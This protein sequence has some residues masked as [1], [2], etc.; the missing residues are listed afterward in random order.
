MKAIFHHTYDVEAANG[1]YHPL[2]FTQKQLEGYA[3]LRSFWATYARC[4]TAV[5]LK[6]YTD[7]PELS[8]TYH[9]ELWGPKEGGFDVYENDVM[10][11]NILLPEENGGQVRAFLARH[12]EF[13][14]LRE[15]TLTPDEDGTDGFYFAV[16]EKKETSADA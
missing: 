11:A 14:L 3:S 2:R 5:S 15:R 10:H 16:L 13:S 6:F 9:T 4:A 7:A 8:F 1:T 12:R